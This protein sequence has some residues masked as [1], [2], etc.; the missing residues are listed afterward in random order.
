[1]KKVIAAIENGRQR[2]ASRFIESDDTRYC[3]SAAIQKHDE[4]YKAHVSVIREENF[5][6]DE[7]DILFTRS[8]SDLQGAIDCVNSNGEIRF[9]EFAALK[10]QK[11][12]NPAIDEENEAR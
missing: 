10:G 11:I 4:E 5:Y 2:G 6:R 1:M 8:F 9:D 3:C 7:F 12:F